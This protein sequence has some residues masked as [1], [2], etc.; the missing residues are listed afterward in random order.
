[1]VAEDREW[2]VYVGREAYRVKAPSYWA[3]RWRGCK[4]Y[5]TEHPTTT[6]TAKRW[7]HSP[8]VKVKVVVDRRYN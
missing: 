7:C 6:K 3:A 2:I 4:R 5:V 1:M 8:S